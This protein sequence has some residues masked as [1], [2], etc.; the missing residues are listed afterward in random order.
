MKSRWSELFFGRWVLIVSTNQLLPI[1]CELLELFLFGCWFIKALSTFL[2]WIVD[3]FYDPTPPLYRRKLV[4]TLCVQLAKKA[5]IV[6]LGGHWWFL[7]LS[8]WQR[9]S[10][11][12]LPFNKRKVGKALITQQPKCKP[13]S[14]INHSEKLQSPN[15]QRKLWLSTFLGRKLVAPLVTQL[16]N[17]TIAY[18]FFFF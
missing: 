3:C 8:N 18:L 15:W 6:Q 11:D 9:K 10:L 7:W 5:P 16:T 17:S 2:L 13:L 1:K 12:H 14:I 4:A